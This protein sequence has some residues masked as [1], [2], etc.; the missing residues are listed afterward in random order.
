MCASLVTVSE[1]VWPQAPATAAEQPGQPGQAPRLGE[2][3]CAPSA[4]EQGL[5][6]EGRRSGA[7]EQVGHVA[8]FA[9]ELDP[10]LVGHGGR[11]VE[12]LVD[13]GRQ[14]GKE[15]VVHEPFAFSAVRG[16]GW[17]A[18]ASGALIVRGFA[19]FAAPSSGVYME[20]TS[21][22]RWRI[23]GAGWAPLCGGR[24]YSPWR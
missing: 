21:A 16:L 13:G 6:A 17:F 15:I 2:S 20:V 24:T 19:A 22:K 3:K 8:P 9:L 14:L 18:G 4:S 23:E 1:R 10:C 12:G 11:H 5:M 7:V